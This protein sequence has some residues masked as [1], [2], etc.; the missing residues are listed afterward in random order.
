MTRYFPSSKR[1]E[2]KEHD[3]RQRDPPARVGPTSIERGLSLD[4]MGNRALLSLLRSGR[5][6][7]KARV[8][9]SG[10]PREHAADRVADAVMAGARPAR[11][12]HGG[13]DAADLQR[14]ATEDEKLAD[15]LGL[16]AE[17]DALALPTSPEESAAPGADVVGHLSGGRSLDQQTREVMESR[18]GESFADVRIHTGHRAGETAEALH[19]RAFT[20][21]E[22]IVF[23]EGE[24]APETTEGRRLLAHEL[25]HVVQQRRTVGGFADAS[26][27]EV[28]ARDAA[29]DV[30]S[31]GAASVRERAKP[32]SIQKASLSE[33]SAE[34]SGGKLPPLGQEGIDW[35]ISA[36]GHDVAE[37]FDLPAEQR[38]HPR[39]WEDT[40]TNTLY[41]DPGAPGARRGAAVTGLGRW[42]TVRL[43][44]GRPIIT[45]PVRPPK[46]KQTPAPSKP[47]RKEAP[48]RPSVIDVPETVITPGEEVAEPITAPPEPDRRPVAEQVVTALKD[49][50]AKAARLAPQLS[51]DELGQLT[52]K[53]RA[54]L[55]HALATNGQPSL[56]IATVLR[57]LQ[58][59]APSQ[60]RELMEELVANDGKVLAALRTSVLPGDR[61]SLEN[62]LFQLQLAA[63][64][65]AGQLG[66]NPNLFDPLGARGFRKLV[67]AP[68]WARDLQF[69]RGASGDWTVMAPGEAPLVIEGPLSRALRAERL[70][71][72]MASFEA[73][74][75]SPKGKV[76][77]I[78]EL[79]EHTWTGPDDEERIINLLRFTPSDEAGRV[80]DGLKMTQSGGKPLIDKLDSV[81]SFDNNV[82]LHEQLAALRMRARKDDPK[83]LSDLANAPV[84]PWRDALFH[85]RAVFSVQTLSD[86]RIAV[87]YGALQSFDLESSKAFGAAMRMLPKEMQHGGTLFLQPDDLV[88]VNDTDG[89]RQV[90]LTAADLVAFQHSGNRGMLK[91]MGDVAS[92][93]MPVG[94]AA[95]GT[96]GVGRAAA[97]AGV[98]LLTMGA[99]EYRMELTRWSPGLMKAIDIAGIALSIK[100][101]V[102]LTKLGAAGVGAIYSRLKKEYDAFKAIR[103]AKIAVSGEAN[104]IRAAEI[105]DA[106]GQGLLRKLEQI[107]SGAPAGGDRPPLLLG[108][109]PKPP[110]LLG[111]GQPPYITPP[112]YQ[113]PASTSP[114]V[115]ENP[116]P[117]VGGPVY[118][119]R[120]LKG[121]YGPPSEGQFVIL[122]DVAG[123]VPATPS[124]EIP[125][126]PA[127]LPPGPEP[128]L[129]GTASTPGVVMDDFAVN[130]MKAADAA[131]QSRAGGL[132]P[133]KG[134]YVRRPGT[135]VPAQ[136]DG[137]Q[138]GE[139]IDAKNYA[140][141]GYFVRGANAFIQNPNSGFAQQWVVRFIDGPLAEA[142]RQLQAAGNVPIVWRVAS[143]EATT[144]LQDIFKAQGIPIRV[145]YFP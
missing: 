41:V 48:T 135:P 33:V 8:S 145:E 2:V 24:F 72:Q 10:D 107:K 121:T 22:D 14:M 119:P 122:H 76:D 126:A 36:D 52:A 93:A 6:Q 49:D 45:P 134:Y 34:V 118:V 115:I 5:L 46:P 66:I 136:F 51:D 102:D 130:N 47:P 108:P 89:N 78:K 137:Y 37:V 82:L 54:D 20:V 13:G 64:L 88:I 30:A 144:I 140:A 56:D 112:Q 100:G 11:I 18:F 143:Q 80:L 105:A 81:T 77:R 39:A 75:L 27:A 28:D 124:T 69:R 42:A 32:G 7:R 141:N 55:L 4:A 127:A 125:S 62:G 70:N 133:G 91:H 103:A 128:K 129:L 16:G 3:L 87:T 79:A 138:G 120:G 17:S 65:R 96:I 71:E 53:D 142:Q 43:T 139:L 63:D 123:G 68:S 35:A 99:N 23:A 50:P 60:Q 38:P 74:Q 84:L 83:L 109:G 31:G 95:R 92:V 98:A 104:A 25:A 97:E 40:D 15:A 131:Y 19:S 9:L 110:L 26:R 21:G 90:P 132:P 57:V 61:N 116:T 44:S 59:T 1:S 86:G 101:G 73:H 114:W 113:L 12:A 111:E 117:T 94:L 29:H 67:G 85:N 58:T 106:Q